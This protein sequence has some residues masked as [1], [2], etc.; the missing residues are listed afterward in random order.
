[1]G[2]AIWGDE[3]Q[4]DEFAC[5]SFREGAVLAGSEWARSRGCKLGALHPML[6][7][8]TSDFDEQRYSTELNGE[9][10]YLRDHRMR[11]DGES[12]Q[13]VMPGVAYLEMARAAMEE[14]LPPVEGAR[15]LEFRDVVWALP[16]VVTENKQVNIRLLANEGPEV[17]YEIYSR[18]GE[19]EVVHG[20]GR[21]MFTAP[22][23]SAAKVDV[24]KLRGEMTQGRI[25]AERLY[26]RLRRLGLEHGSGMKAVRWIE[27]GQ[28]QVLAE[29]HITPEAE[30]EKGKYGLHPSLLDGALQASVA[31][32]MAVDEE[33]EKGELRVP[34]S[35]ERMWVEGEAAAEMLA[36]VRWSAQTGE[37]QKVEKLDIDLC[38][39]RGSVALRMR[40]LSV[41]QLGKQISKA[42]APDLGVGRLI[43]VQ[44]EGVGA[45]RLEYG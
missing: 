41:R 28:G 12:V 24:E 5:I 15:V 36:W 35:L 45:E 4:E 8:N 26:E 37:G 1:M 18:A 39:L 34:F 14:V 10:F 21:M 20:L 30:E 19:E 25:E 43:A 33:Q 38:D 22:E 40:G 3:A 29:L 9:E 6:H 17:E 16:I 27:R 31:L 2:E 42:A 11:V 13:K 44:E 32:M 7:R 23:E